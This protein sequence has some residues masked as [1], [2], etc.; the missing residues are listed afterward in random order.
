MENCERDRNQVLL[1]VAAALASMLAKGRSHDE[2]HQLADFF[3]AI[4]DNLILLAGYPRR[5]KD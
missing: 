5:K 1:A 2:I 4:R 3:S